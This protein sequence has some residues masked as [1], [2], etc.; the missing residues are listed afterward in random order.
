[1]NIVYHVFKVIKLKL[2]MVLKM[3]TIAFDHFSNSQFH[4]PFTLPF[5]LSLFSLSFCLPFLS[6]LFPFPFYFSFLFIFNL[7]CGD[8]HPSFSFIFVFSL[9]LYLA[10]L[11]FLFLFPFCSS[12]LFIL[13]WGVRAPTSPDFVSDLTLSDTCYMKIE[14]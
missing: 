8:L 2:L 7:G 12:S 9:S 5:L 11:S 3:L 6:F 14:D 13:T 4:I 10:F 1:M